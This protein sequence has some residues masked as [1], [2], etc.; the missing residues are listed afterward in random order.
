MK[1][2]HHYAAAPAASPA[3]AVPVSLVACYAAWLKARRGKRPSANQLAFEVRWLDRLLALKTAL[4]T[5]NWQP[6]RTVSF[7]VSHPK[8]RE[9]HAPDFADRVVHHLLVERLEKLYEPVFI[10]DSYANRKGR[11]GHAAVDR[12]QQFMRS[13]NGQGCYLQLD[14]HNYFNSINRPILYQMLCHRLQQCE[15]RAGLPAA[16]AL[17]LRSLCHKLLANKVSASMRDPAAAARVPP[18]KRLANAA[19]ACGIPVG[20]LSSQFFANVYLNA[21]DQFVKHTLKCRHYVRYVDDFVLLAKDAAQLRVWQAQINEFL[22]ATLGLKCKDAVRLQ[23]MCQ[24]IDFLGYHVFAGHRRVRPRVV[25]HCRAKLQDWA[26][27]YVRA[28]IEGMIINPENPYTRHAVAHR[29]PAT[30]NSR[31]EQ[32][33]AL[34][35]PSRA[36]FFG[37]CQNDANHALANLQAQLGSY[38]GHFAHANSVRLR[39]ALF[40]QF[41]WLKSLFILHPDGHLTPRWVLQGATFVAQAVALQAEWPQAQCL[42]QKGNRWVRL[43]QPGQELNAP[44]SQRLTASLRRQGIAYVCANQTGWLRHGTRRRE[45][46]AWFNPKAVAL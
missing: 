43:S 13:R 23:P 30:V 4:R 31:S 14:I 7:I 24:G 45:V 35:P 25:A 29:N 9:I 27:R 1:A 42:I 12:L 3:I 18:H 22:A 28:A 8:T 11:G 15:Q 21:L 33:S 46:R 6:A 40:D 17:A 38:W 37:L 32:N 10:H 19:P 26:A 2:G 16:H 41:A 44:A 36:M 34:N 20:N 5:G 39:H